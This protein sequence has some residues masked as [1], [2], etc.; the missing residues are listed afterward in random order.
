MTP[1]QPAK[2]NGEGTKHTVDLPDLRLLGVH[3]S[4]ILV[5]DDEPLIR[6]SGHPCYC[7]TMGTSSFPLPMVTKGWNC[8]AGVI[9]LQITDV[10]MP[11]LAE[12][13]KS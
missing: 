2:V 8:H 10:A 13:P 5:A 1:E 3:Q 7:S 4:V 11:S 12:S 6:K 9:D